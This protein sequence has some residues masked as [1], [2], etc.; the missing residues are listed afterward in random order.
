MGNVSGAMEEFEEVTRLAPQDGVDESAAKANYSLG[1]VLEEQARHAD[2]LRHLDDAV[3]YQPN[4]LEAHLALG[5][6]LRRSHQRGRGS[7]AGG[8]AERS[9]RFKASL[10][11]YDEAMRI[12]PRSTPA[13]L[14][15][16]LALTALGR[17]QEA[18]DWLIESTTL[19]PDRQE[20]GIALA[21][22]LAA[23]PD[24]RVR[25][26]RRALAVSDKLFDQQ[27]GTNVARHWRWRLPSSATTIARSAFN[28]A[29]LPRWS[30]RDCRRRRSA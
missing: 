8:P 15:H 29:S 4:Y 24:D 14:G 17:W 20:F 25:D 13:R 6:A 28:A 30:R 1:I 16:A 5:D 9:V 12:D 23:S 11:H 3:K 22:L 27:K 2:A 18:R 7:D 26:G 10:A 19:Y 21:R